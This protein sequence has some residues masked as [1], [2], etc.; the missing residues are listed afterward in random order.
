MIEKEN[1]CL[2]GKQ[3]GVVG[4]GGIHCEPSTVVISAIYS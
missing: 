2:V 1:H 3:D 4:V